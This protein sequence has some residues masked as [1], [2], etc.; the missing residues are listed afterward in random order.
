MSGEEVF[1]KAESLNFTTIVYEGAKCP[2]NEAEEPVG[3]AL[4]ITMLAPLVLKISHEIHMIGENLKLG[5]S[6]AE[7][8]MLEAGTGKPLS[9][10]LGSF[11]EKEGRRFALHLCNLAGAPVC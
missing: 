8:H 11:E 3:G 2:L 1:F 10:M 5:A 9:V 6:K 4:K 7:T